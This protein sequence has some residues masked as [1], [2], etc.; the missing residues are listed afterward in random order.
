M[1]TQR[2]IIN[3]VLTKD[4]ASLEF[5]LAA[6]DKGIAEA[7]KAVS[8]ATQTLEGMRTE[9]DRVADTLDAIRAEL[10]AIADRE[11]SIKP[12]R[13][14]MAEHGPRIPVYLDSERDATTGPN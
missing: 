1:R 9:R 7:N 3:G 11:P 5:Q 10:A 4:F 6:L 12:N 14:I 8:A 2:G 13:F